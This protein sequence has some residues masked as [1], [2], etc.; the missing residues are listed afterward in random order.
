ME[1]DDR[2]RLTPRSFHLGIRALAAL[3]HQP[4]RL[5][6]LPALFLIET[7]AVGLPTLAI[8][9]LVERPSL[10]VTAVIVLTSATAFAVW[11]ATSQQIPDGQGGFALLTPTYGGLIAAVLLGGADWILQA[12]GKT[13]TGLE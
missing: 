2:G 10:F 8:L 13:Q 5:N 4:G 1:I 7:F 6:V 11:A 9:A 12:F 3:R